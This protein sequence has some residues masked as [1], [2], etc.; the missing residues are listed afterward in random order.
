[1]SSD[2][3]E[4]SEGR[5]MELLQERRRSNL[6]L[7]SVL[8][9]HESRGYSAV[10]GTYNLSTWSHSP[11]QCLPLMFLNFGKNQLFSLSGILSTHAF[12][13]CEA[14]GFWSD[15]W[16]NWLTRITRIVSIVSLIQGLIWYSWSWTRKMRCLTGSWPIISFLST[17]REQ[18]SRKW[19]TWCVLFPLLHDKTC[20]TVMS[21]NL[22]VTTRTSVFFPD[23]SNGRNTKLSN[24]TCNWFDEVRLQLPC[25]KGVCVLFQ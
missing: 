18:R 3:S 6:G 14:I 16:W 2:Q 25:S 19:S 22:V 23:T 9:T 17:T 20:N 12:D 21:A 11:C 7:A 10:P 1:M 8:A 13:L 15:L 24:H 4:V 5:P